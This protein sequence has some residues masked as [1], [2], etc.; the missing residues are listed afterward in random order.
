VRG[1]PSVPCQKGFSRR[2]ATHHL[3]GGVEDSLPIVD[4]KGTFGSAGSPSFLRNASSGTLAKPL[5]L[6][7]WS[8]VKNSVVE[9]VRQAYS[10]SASLGSRTRF[11]V[12][13]LNY[14]QNFTASFQL[15]FP[16][17]WSLVCGH[18]GLRQMYCG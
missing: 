10:H 5:R 4:G 17:G 8:P 3:S 1:L 15:T 16:T 11:P 12:F 9:P 14:S 13:L 2:E 7:G 6:A 18:P